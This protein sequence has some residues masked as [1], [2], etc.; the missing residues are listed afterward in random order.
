MAVSPK[1]KRKHIY[2]NKTYYWSV[3][4][5]SEGILRIHIISDDKKTNLERSMFD[6]ELP[7]TGAYIN[8]LLDGDC[9]K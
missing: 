6:T 9:K 8:K 5:N 2:K 1:G 3:R 7:V 4:K